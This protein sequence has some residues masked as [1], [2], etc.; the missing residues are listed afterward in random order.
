MSLQLSPKAR[1]TRVLRHLDASETDFHTMKD[2]RVSAQIRDQAVT[3]YARLADVILD[4]LRAL[5]RMGALD[6]V[7]DLLD[8]TYGES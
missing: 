6:D 2:D 8:L 3:N 5:R 4:D 7:S 1:W